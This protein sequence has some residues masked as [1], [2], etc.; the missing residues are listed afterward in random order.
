MTPSPRATGCFLIG[1][2]G[3]GWTEDGC[4]I[5]GSVSDDPYDIRTFVRVIR[6]DEGYV[7]L[8]TEL[9]ST[10]EHT[11]EE[12]GYLCKPYETTRAVNEAG[13][14]FTCAGVFERSDL[15]PASEPSEFMEATSG[16]LRVCADVD[17]AIAHLRGIAFTTLAWNVL[18]ADATGAIA[19]VE[20][21]RAGFSVVGKHMPSDPGVLITVNCYVNL[22]EFNDDASLIT[23]LANNNA[24]RF[25]RGQH[26][27]HN[28][29]GAISARTIADM[30]ADHANADRDPLSNPVLDAWGYSICN[31]GTRGTDTYPYENL[32]WGTV[33]AEI[34]EPRDRRLWY[35]YGWPCGSPAEHGDQLLQPNSWGRFLPFVLDDTRPGACTTP[36]GEITPFGVRYVHGSPI[37]PVTS[38]HALTAV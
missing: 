15:V 27:A 34:L 6:P 16:M 38:V 23:N 1:A 2:T 36:S 17:E 31:H 29:K 13:L 8:G 25:E 37:A 22:A 3:E 24:C 18:L 7:H 20:I 9:I 11:L 30:L 5:L 28:T 10:T 14:A 26:L 32:P 21:G 4:A 12:R 35:A 19:Q 33:S